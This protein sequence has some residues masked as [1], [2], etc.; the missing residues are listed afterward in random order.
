M[1]ARASKHKRISAAL[2]LSLILHFVFM[3]IFGFLYIQT[4]RQVE[5]GALQVEILEGRQRTLPKPLKRPLSL[6]MTDS[7]NRDAHEMAPAA[8]L[9]RPV[10]SPTFAVPQ[11]SSPLKTSLPVLAEE[12][13]PLS[14]AHGAIHTRFLGPSG[15]A[16]SDGGAGSGLKG[17]AAS[18]YQIRRESG[19]LGLERSASVPDIGGFTKPDLALTKIARNILLDHKGKRIDIVF[20]IDASQSMRNDIEAVRDRLTQMTDLLEAGGLDFTVGVVAFRDATAYSLFGWDFQVTPQ[21]NSV[22]RIKE[23]LNDISCRGGEKA[24]N[25]LMR[26]AEEVKF[27]KGVERRFILATDEYVTGDYSLK[28]VLRKMESARIRVDVIGREQPFQTVLA[29]HTGGLWLP[30]SSLKE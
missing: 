7:K 30:I 25:A 24:S 5:E 11:P 2:F 22:Q 18:G 10:L 23:A 21:T 3:A 1:G 13:T 19:S 28:E 14:D 20:I 12:T 15:G 17:G 9:S 26:A 8:P 16:A 6:S 29:E 4:R 27:R